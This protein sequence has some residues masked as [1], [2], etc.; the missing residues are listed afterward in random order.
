[1]SLSTVPLLK[2]PECK[3]MESKHVFPLSEGGISGMAR[4]D[5]GRVC[6]GDFPPMRLPVLPRSTG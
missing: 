5:S 3:T 1:M 6:R 2:M 4:G